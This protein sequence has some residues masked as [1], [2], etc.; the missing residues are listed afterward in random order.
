MEADA[1]EPARDLQVLDAT[2]RLQC[3]A[4]LGVADPRD[5]EVLVGRLVAE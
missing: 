3:G 1:D 5:E 4:E 2:V